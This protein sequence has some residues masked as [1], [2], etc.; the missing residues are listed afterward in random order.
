MAAAVH[1]TCFDVHG[2]GTT[3]RTLFSCFVRRGWTYKYLRVAK[4]VVSLTVPA[5]LAPSLLVVVVFC[6]LVPVRDGD[7]KVACILHAHL[8]LLFKNLGVD[9]V[10]KTVASVVLSAQV[11]FSVEQSVPYIELQASFER[12]FD[13]A[14]SI[15]SPYPKVSIDWHGGFSVGLIEDRCDKGDCS[16][17]CVLSTQ[18]FFVGMLGMLYFVWSNVVTI[19][20]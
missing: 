6:G 16:W 10:N 7:T 9:D 11:C 8:L 12:L 13:R 18:Q 14:A 3:R 5:L 15:Y 17:R 20:T 2:T 4:S 19:L 1:C